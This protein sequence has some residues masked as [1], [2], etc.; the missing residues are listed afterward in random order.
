MLLSGHQGEIYSCK[1]H[2]N[3]QTI[4]S[5]GFDR[6]LYLWNTYG[7]CENYAA[8]TG[9]KGSIL[10]LQFSENGDRIFTSSSDKTINMWDS[11]SGVRIKK[12]KAH[13]NIVNAISTSRK[14]TSL[15]ASVGDDCSI[16]IWDTRTRAVVKSFKD[17]Y[18]LLACTFNEHAD[19]V[20]VAGIENVLRVYDLRKDE[21]MYSMVGHYDSVTGLALSPDGSHVL[22]N[23]MD[24]TLCIWDIRP[25]AP[26]ERCVKTLHGH[27]HNFEKNLLRCAW[28]PDGTKVTAGS[29]DRNVYIWDTNQ[30]RIL[31]K[32]PGHQG[33]VNE[34]RFHPN[35][36]IVLS[37]SS[38][39]NLYLGE[40][41]L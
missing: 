3:G 13:G 2:P 17:D 27:Q 34:V 10:D 22:S 33:S 29:G 31:Y 30:R 16:K 36:P 38:D 12:L 7:E 32:L 23:S 11:A 1:F 9:H 40:V 8:L 39:K 18:Q 28:S 26:A 6:Q 19:Q 15:L 14:S 25:F 37:G 21:F 24:N 5:G 41:E 35:E 20:I 4:A